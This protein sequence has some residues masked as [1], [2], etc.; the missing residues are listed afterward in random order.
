MLCAL[1]VTTFAPTAFAQSVGP[2]SAAPN[3]PTTSAS[4]APAATDSPAIAE[5]RERQQRGR[6]LIAAREFNNT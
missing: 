5:A 6:A 4:V 1:L 3:A 2:A